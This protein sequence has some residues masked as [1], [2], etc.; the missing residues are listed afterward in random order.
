MIFIP[1]WRLDLVSSSIAPSP[2]FRNI[3]ALV[4]I[5]LLPPVMWPWAVFF[6]S[7]SLGF[8]NYNQYWWLSSGI[9]VEFFHASWP[10]DTFCSHFFLNLVTWEDAREGSLTL[11]FHR[12]TPCAE[13]KVGPKVPTRAGTRVWTVDHSVWNKSHCRKSRTCVPCYLFS[14]PWAWRKTSFLLPLSGPHLLSFWSLILHPLNKQ[15]PFP[16]G[17]RET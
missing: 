8:I 13:P 5:L 11:S 9:Y 15:P 2:G 14:L 16:H 10:W 17:D 6:F 3:G 4:W 12:K 7:L 1:G